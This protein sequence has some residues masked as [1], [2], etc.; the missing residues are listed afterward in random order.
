MIAIDDFFFFV[1]NSYHNFIE[2]I[3]TSVGYHKIGSITHH[4]GCLL[5]KEQEMKLAAARLES[6]TRLP[7]AAKQSESE[8]R[9]LK[10]TSESPSNTTSWIPISRAKCIARRQDMASTFSTD[11]GRLILSKRAAIT[12]PSESWITTP[13]PAIR[14][15]WKID[16][17]ITA[18]RIKMNNLMVP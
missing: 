10:I 8:V 4:C 2:S 12:S 6:S 13:I 1:K 7:K 18:L 3:E 16:D 14:I 9:C 15:S 11:G 17:F 5:T